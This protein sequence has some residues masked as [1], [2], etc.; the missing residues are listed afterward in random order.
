[1]RFRS[2]LLRSCHAPPLSSGAA[3]GFFLLPLSPDL[4]LCVGLILSALPLDGPPVVHSLL[5]LLIARIVHVRFLRCAAEPAGL[6][7]CQ[8]FGPPEIDRPS[9]SERLVPP[10]NDKQFVCARV[11]DQLIG[12]D[13]RPPDFVHVEVSAL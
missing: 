7:L 8:H 9:A 4:L 6:H 5:V 12:L 2:S 11:L 13:E 1:E 3:L 10:C